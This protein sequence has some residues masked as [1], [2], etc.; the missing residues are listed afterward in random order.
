MDEVG[1]CWPITLVKRYH[2]YPPAIAPQQ[3]FILAANRVGIQM[4]AIWSPKPQKLVPSGQVY[5]QV[6]ALNMFLESCTVFERNN[7]ETSN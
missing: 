5:Q 3:H 1:I 4:D 7:E 2:S 6:G